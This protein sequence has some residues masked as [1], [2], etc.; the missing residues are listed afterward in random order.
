MVDLWACPFV[1]GEQN[2]TW[3]Y[4]GGV[5]SKPQ[6]SIENHLLQWRKLEKT[7]MHTVQYIVWVTVEVGTI[8]LILLVMFT[9]TACS[10]HFT[11][12]LHYLVAVAYVIPKVYARPSPSLLFPHRIKSVLDSS[13]IVETTVRLRARWN[14]AVEIALLYFLRLC[15]DL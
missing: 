2:Q 3:H 10:V 13:L 9:N 1:Y 6:R 5:S 15:L 7:I 8:P 12:L 4:Y 14:H 11:L